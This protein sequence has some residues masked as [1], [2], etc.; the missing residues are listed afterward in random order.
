MSIRPLPLIALAFTTASFAAAADLQIPMGDLLDEAPNARTY[1]ND[2]GQ[3]KVLYNAPLA[4]GQNAKETAT[5]FLESHSDLWNVTSENLRPI[6]RFSNGKHLQP[7]MPRRTAE[8]LVNGYTFTGVYYSQ[9]AGEYPVWR[10]GLCLLV[11]NTD[12]RTG[13]GDS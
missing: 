9:F 11:N 1:L 4:T 5:R 3:I 13:H 12:L 6:D 10:S 2:A 7:I 8:G